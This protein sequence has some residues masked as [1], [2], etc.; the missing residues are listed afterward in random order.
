MKGKVD[1]K[2]I[3]ALLL[4]TFIPSVYA[5][6]IKC[7]GATYNVEVE[8]FIEPYT[9]GLTKLTITNGK[10]KL[11]K[12][13]ESVKFQIGCKLNP[14]N[15]SYIIYQ[16]YSNCE[17]QTCTAADNNW[18]I[19]DPSS[20]RIL[21]EPSNDNHEKAEQIFGGELRP[22]TKRKRSKTTAP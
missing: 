3:L 16:A 1:M 22:F 10:E 18:G 17:D 15:T 2:M 5:E 21:L 9:Y 11:L 19:V 6:P 4:M 20:L 14:A 8:G 13:F 7:D 12:Q